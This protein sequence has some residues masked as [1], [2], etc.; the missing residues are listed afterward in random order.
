MES[1]SSLGRGMHK[2]GKGSKGGG[3][4][5]SVRH[6]PRVQWTRGQALSSP[7]IMSSHLDRRK[8]GSHKLIADRYRCNKRKRQGPDMENKKSTVFKWSVKYS[9][10][11]CGQNDE[12]EQTI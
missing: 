5:P 11:K 10:W 2:N 9:L 6:A 12:K 1:E 3:M 4:R 7:T 8:I